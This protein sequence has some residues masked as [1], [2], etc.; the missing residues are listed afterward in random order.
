[1]DSALSARHN[2]WMDPCSCIQADLTYPNLAYHLNIN[3]R[4][5]FQTR[6]N[7]LTTFTTVPPIF[8]QNMD[9]VTTELTE[10]FERYCDTKEDQVPNDVLTELQSI[11][12]LYSISPEE[13]DFKWQA[14]NMKMGGEE[15]KMDLKTARDFRKTIQDALER[16]SKQKAHQRNEVKRAQPTPRA[17]GGD[18]YDMYVHI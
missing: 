4:R 16:E 11:L 5:V 9:D 6:K 14:Y 12:H 1:V 13:L 2:F 3:T 10:R 18:M 8:V 7:T 17:K 15:N